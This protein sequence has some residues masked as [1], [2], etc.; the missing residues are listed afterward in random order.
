MK[1][2]DQERRKKKGE[3]KM[4]L[5]TEQAN[6]SFKQEKDLEIKTDDLVVSYLYDVLL[7]LEFLSNL[8]NLSFNIENIFYFSLHNILTSVSRFGTTLRIQ[9]KDVFIIFDHFL[10]KSYICLLSV[11]K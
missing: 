9:Q 7:L 8:S 10:Y 4:Q 5:D 3:E 6:M 1:Q 11:V 2:L